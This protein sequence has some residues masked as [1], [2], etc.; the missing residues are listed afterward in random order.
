[1][2]P[3]PTNTTFLESRRRVGGTLSVTT[4]CE[5]I[6]AA[7]ICDGEAFEF[8]AAAVG[9]KII[10]FRSRGLGFDSADPSSG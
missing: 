10:D 2:R 3:V 4:G 7:E 1:V 6:F 5:R 8:L 9:C